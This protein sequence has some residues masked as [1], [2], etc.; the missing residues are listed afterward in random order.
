ML[1]RRMR[2]LR[3]FD[4]ALGKRPRQIPNHFLVPIAT[5]RLL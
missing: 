2:L 4:V 5:R 3:L 1:S